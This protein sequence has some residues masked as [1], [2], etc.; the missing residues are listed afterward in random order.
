MST[1]L[2]QIVAGKWEEIAE[3]R[4]RTPEADLERR[5]REM[6]PA[7]DFQGAL[8]RPGTVQVIAEVKK[9][10]PSA[11]VLRADFDPVGIATAYEANGAACVSVLTDERYF[12]GHLRYLSDIRQSVQ[13]P[14][15]R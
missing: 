10:S 13:L 5:A 14:L 15:L 3:A 4:R 7:R 11:G 2:D 6:P 9:A 1:I 8:V 12:Q